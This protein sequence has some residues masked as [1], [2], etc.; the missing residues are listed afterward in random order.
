VPTL[1]LALVV[2]LLAA[3]GAAIAQHRWPLAGWI[4]SALLGASLYAIAPD[5][6]LWPDPELAR[7][8]GLP[9]LLFA[10]AWQLE[11]RLVK[12]QL[13]P[14]LLLAL[15][16]PAIAT[17][18]IGSALV[19]LS[20]LSLIDSLLLGVALAATSPVA[21]AP[22]LQAA[23]TPHTLSALLA[24]ESALNQLAAALGFS[25]IASLAT[26]AA[27]EPAAWQPW[28]QARAIAGLGGLALGSLSGLLLYLSLRAAR[29][30]PYV[31]VTLSLAATWLLF[32][33][34]ESW[35]FSG[36]IA[37]VL[38]GLVAGWRAASDFSP[39]QRE[40]LQ[41][42]WAYL[43]YT[44]SALACILA[45]WAAA[46]SLNTLDTWFT[47]VWLLLVVLLAGAIARALAAYLLI[48]LAN[49][50]RQVT[51]LDWRWQTLLLAGGVR[52]PLALVLLFSWPRA[53]E[54]PR[55]LLL[56]LA[57]GLLL[58]SAGLARA[59]LDNLARYLEL[60]RPHLAARVEG[61][62]ALLTA[63]RE[64]LRQF[65]D[66]E[67]LQPWAGQALDA[68]AQD[69]SEAVYQ[70]E[71][72]LNA[73]WTD[74]RLPAYDLRQVLWLQALNIEVMGYRYLYDR[75]L[76]SEPV[77]A[78]L[79]LR[80]T[81]RRDAVLQGAMPPPFFTLRPPTT[82]W[83]LTLGKWVGLNRDD[84]LR[85][86]AA[87]AKYEADAAIACVCAQVAQTLERSLEEGNLDRAIAGECAAAYRDDSEVAQRNLTAAA[88]QAPQENRNRQQQL[89]RRV[90]MLGE[91]DAL[92]QLV[93]DG[94][95]ASDL[96][97][98]LRDR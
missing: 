64:A 60:A 18:A 25:A 85:Q 82:A 34:V 98:Q 5:R 84:G 94:T 29:R 12:T 77:L 17:A 89:A 1:H 26:T 15:L 33:W 79:E 48:P 91:Q 13:S 80:V 74:R 61:L 66:L 24:G 53:D 22:V 9:P 38:L 56:A 16:G 21:I 87:L 97:R 49:A 43:A 30:Q 90:A 68:I 92:E 51:P 11:G 73:I 39:S 54:S 67:R 59:S 7:W 28:L 62:Q 88:S 40:L 72:S 41:Q 19:Y 35:Q 69:Y 37:V 76:L 71:Q 96:A 27:L 46:A 55:G 93:R 36:A 95:L 44:I 75:G 3:C 81:L 57:L 45:G 23:G 10:S 42:L 20:P 63:K 83:Y 8:F 32:G 31:Q 52:S 4:A 6:E 14:V 65:A 78:K 2:L 50:L 47:Y 70:A 86:R 58:L